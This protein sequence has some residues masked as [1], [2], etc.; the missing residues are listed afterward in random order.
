[1]SSIDRLMLTIGS[2]VS[3]NVYKQFINRD[4]SEKSITMLSRVAILVS[5][6][7]IPYLALSNPHELLAWLIWWP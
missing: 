6:A 2:Y 1:M 5:T 3:W 7:I 4:A